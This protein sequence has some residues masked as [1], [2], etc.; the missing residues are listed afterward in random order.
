MSS[1]LS[2]ILRSQNLYYEKKGGVIML[3][4]LADLALLVWTMN[5]MLKN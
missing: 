1:R 2:D 3:R 4:K 5:Y